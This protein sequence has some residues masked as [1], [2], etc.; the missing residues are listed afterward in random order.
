MITFGSHYLGTNDTS[1]I[2]DTNNCCDP[3]PPPVINSWACVKKAL[4]PGPTGISPSGWRYVC[5][6]VGPNGPGALYE[7]L[8]VCES[9]PCQR[10]K[11]II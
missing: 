9:S 4:P 2:N 10:P 3:A 6:D 8:Q 11:Y 5:E 7:S 1:C